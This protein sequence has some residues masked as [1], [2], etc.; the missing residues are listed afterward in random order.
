MTDCIFCKIARSEIPSEKVYENEDLV[1]VRDIHPAAPTHVLIIPK[2]H[3]A[4]LNDADGV[5]DGTLASIL[6]AAKEIATREGIADEGYRVVINCN[7][8]GGQEV[9]HLHVHVLGGRP[10]GRMG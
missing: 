9:F 3:V 6:R 2:T 4:T 7:R 8:A 10:M 5:Q 1:A